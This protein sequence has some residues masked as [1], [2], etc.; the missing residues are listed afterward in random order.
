MDLYSAVILITMLLLMITIADVLT[1]RLI[2]KA[3]KLCSLLASLLIAGAAL[4]ELVGVLTNGAPSAFMVPHK[5]AKTAEFALAP[6]V[7]VFAAIAYGDPAK[8]RL[9]LALFLR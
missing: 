3:T 9:A 7:G 8:P 1:N 6:L 4:G 2:T 5:I